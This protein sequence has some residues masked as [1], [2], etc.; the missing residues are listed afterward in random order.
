MPKRSTF[1]DANFCPGAKDFGMTPTF[2][3]STP[4]TS[5]ATNGETVLNFQ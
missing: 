4:I 2:P 1:F 5:D 3:M